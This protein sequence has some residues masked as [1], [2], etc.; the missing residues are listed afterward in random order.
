MLIDA[1][2]KGVTEYDIT[3]VLHI[4]SVRHNREIRQNER[5]CIKLLT[6]KLALDRELL[7]MC[8]YVQW[9]PYFTAQTSVLCLD[10]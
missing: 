10:D 8:G 6:E 7:S 4:E 9:S 3:H 2:S 1:P 5:R